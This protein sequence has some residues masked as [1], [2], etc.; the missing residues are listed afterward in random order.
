MAVEPRRGRQYHY[1]KEVTQMFQEE[2]Y[3]A[4][5]EE[6]VYE[7]ETLVC[8]DCGNEFVFTAGE[9]RFYAE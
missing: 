5:V 2:N 1:Q 9:Q 3:D 4:A 7:D 8:K 6:K